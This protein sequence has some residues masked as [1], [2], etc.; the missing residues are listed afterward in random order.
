MRSRYLVLAAVLLSSACS[1]PQRTSVP[2]AA[3]LSPAAVLTVRETVTVRDTV[4]ERRAAR[5]EFRILEREAQLEEL[6]ARLN[7]TRDEVVRTMAKLRRAASRAEA[8]SG[9][10]EAE[11]SL[12]SLRSSAGQRQLPEVS[13]ATRLVQQSSAEFNKQNFGG[14]LYLATQAKTVAGS[15]RSRVDPRNRGASLPGETPF[16]APVRL[17]IA[18]RGNVRAGPSTTFG[19]AFTVEAGSV[20]TGHSHTDEWIR[21]SDDSGKNGWIFRTLVARP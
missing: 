4:A 17:K 9:M 10:A 8:A 21:I 15:G 16:A 20:L 13:E 6:Q 18:S 19:V 3:Q 11:V 2:V 5:L 12:Q 1:S 14:A 7:D